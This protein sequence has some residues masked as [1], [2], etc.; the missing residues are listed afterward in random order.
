MNIP[1]KILV[2]VLVILALHLQVMAQQ[3]GVH[4]F[5]CFTVIAG[6]NA[7]SDGS[8]LFA[9]N[10]DDYGTRIVNWFKV[11]HKFHDTA[12]F[13]IINSSGATIRQVAEANAYLWL[14]MPEMEF[15]DTYMNEYGVVIAS[16][17]C[18]SREDNPELTEGG[19][20]YWLRRIMA[21]R[22][23]SA[24][25]GV[26][27]GGELIERFGYTG[28]GRSYFIADPDEAWIMNVVQGKHWVA[29]RIPDDRVAVVPNY[30]T[31]HHVNLRDTANFLASPDLIGYA[32]AKGWYDPARDGEFSFRKAYSSPDKLIHKSNISRRWK[33]INALSLYEYKLEDEFPFA[34]LPKKKIS[35]ADLMNLL[36]DHYEGTP[37]DLTNGYK[38][39]NPHFTENDPICSP[40]TQYGFVAQLRNYLPVGM[41]AVLWIAPYRPCVHPFTPWYCGVTEIPESYR[42]YP[43]Y[44]ALENHFNPPDDL[45][46]VT[47]SHAY[48]YYHEHARQIDEA[49]GE[50]SGK[51]RK[52]SEAFEKKYI[53]KQVAF[54]QEVLF[55]YKNDKAALKREVTGFT[56]EAATDVLK[57]FK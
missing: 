20:G 12:M 46:T 34:F 7:T 41:G 6:R 55:E 29:Q 35:P 38:D 13:V 45:Y 44:E 42:K 53:R 3:P 23:R 33:G 17:Q 48:W 50:L 43:A 31:I 36:R 16:D 21:E 27:I 15:S 26:I 56:Q 14:D 22:A 51:A 10:E 47:D 49:Y 28:S 8:V 1:R 32:M 11:E 30:Y 24:R 25:E 9:H 54:E 57:L 39:G 5:N 37:L 52:A 2:F 19:I 18:D 40:T 4:H